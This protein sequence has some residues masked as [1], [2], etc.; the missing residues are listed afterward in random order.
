MAMSYELWAVS[1][2]QDRNPKLAALSALWKKVLTAE[3]TV[4]I[5]R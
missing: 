1:Y 5:R 4:D 2:Q 3:A